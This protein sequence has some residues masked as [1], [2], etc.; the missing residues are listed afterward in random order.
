VR[1]PQHGYAQSLKETHPCANPKCKF[2]SL[3]DGFGRHQKVSARSRFWRFQV[4]GGSAENLSKT[5]VFKAPPSR[6]G[7]H[8]LKPSKW[9]ES[10]HH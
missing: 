6:H 7:I 3:H 4:L 10:L 8:D 5:K 2:F 1:I 9:N